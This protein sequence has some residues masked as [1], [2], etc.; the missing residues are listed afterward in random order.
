MEIWIEQQ[1]EILTIL[2]D[3]TSKPVMQSTITVQSIQVSKYSGAGQHIPNMM[4]KVTA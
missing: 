1:C 2:E 4:G 3:I